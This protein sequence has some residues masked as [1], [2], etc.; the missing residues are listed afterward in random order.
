MDNRIQAP[1]IIGGSIITASLILRRGISKLTE[2]ITYAIN[3]NSLISN[4]SRFGQLDDTSVAVI[5]D[6]AYFVQNGTLWIADFVDDDLLME[7]ARPIDLM[8]LDKPL[9]KEAMMAVDVLT[10]IKEHIGLD[11]D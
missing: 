3:R 6:H 5:D 8:S 1:L 11:E 2:D 7:T 4:F 9:L 10:D